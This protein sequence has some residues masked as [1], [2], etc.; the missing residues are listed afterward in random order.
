MKQLMNKLRSVKGLGLL[1]AGLA[2]GIV[3]LIL[4]SSADSTG[5]T[6]PASEDFSFESYEKS[7]SERLSQM[8]ERVDGVSDVHVM[9][10]LERG[11]SDE[12]A[13]DG[14]EYLTVKHS[15]GAEGTVILSREAPQVRG[16]AVICQGGDDP[17]IQIE[18][19]ELISALFHL[20]A[21]RIF[22]SEG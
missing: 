3:L 14:D 16:V 15:D 9:L 21:G 2:I 17:D 6:A 10:T 12:L 18:I 11:Y 1:I 13:K 8:L 20:S 4:G 19:I 7:L 5:D 22:V